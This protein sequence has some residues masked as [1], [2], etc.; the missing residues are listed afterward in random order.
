MHDK[1]SNRSRRPES[2]SLR[3]VRLPQ[4]SLLQHVIT[5]W[6]QSGGRRQPHLA[7]EHARRTC[8]IAS[9]GQTECGTGGR[10][11]SSSARGGSVCR[12]AGTHGEET[13]YFVHYIFKE[14]A[15]DIARGIF[16]LQKR[17]CHTVLNFEEVG[18]RI[19]H[20]PGSC[21]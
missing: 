5:T 15:D 7:A 10:T 13:N 12:K 11:Q 19:Q 16:C 1:R 3:L 2:N 14:D 18:S 17:F 20:Q 8:P 9:G 4:L 6:T 21:S